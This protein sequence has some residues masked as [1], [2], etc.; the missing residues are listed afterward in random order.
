MK[1]LRFRSVQY[2]TF[3]KFEVKCL[4]EG[5]VNPKFYL[6]VFKGFEIMQYDCKVDLDKMSIYLSYP[7]FSLR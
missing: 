2:F 5:T 6:Q 4:K 3:E 7:P 1:H